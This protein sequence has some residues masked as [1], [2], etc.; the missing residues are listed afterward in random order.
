MNEITPEKVRTFLL[1][2]YADKIKGMGLDPATIP[3]TFDFLLEG[4]VDSLGILEMVGAIE[5]EFGLEL[6]LAGLDAEQ[7]TVLG[8]LASYVAGHANTKRNGPEEPAAPH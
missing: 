1:D 6:D 2:R 3:D 8:P 7:M 4:A 5:K